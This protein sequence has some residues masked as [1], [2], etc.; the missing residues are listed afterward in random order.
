MEKQTK[1]NGPRNMRAIILA[2]LGIIL[3]VVGLGIITIHGAPLRGSGFG[4]A[5]T[6]LGFL[7]LVIAFLRF[8]YKR[9]Q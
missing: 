5:F 3:V 4:T 7:L 9:P 2:L 8:Y 1:T 6:V